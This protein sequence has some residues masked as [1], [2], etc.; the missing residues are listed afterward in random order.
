MLLGAFGKSDPECA[1][2]RRA[3]VRNTTITKNHSQS[4][5]RHI[6]AGGICYCPSCCNARTVGVVEIPK[7]PWD[8][9]CEQV[10]LWKS[11]LLKD[12]SLELSG[13]HFPSFF[14]AERFE[15]RRSLVLG[16]G[17]SVGLGDG[18]FELV[19]LQSPHRC[20]R[21][22]KSVV[23]AHIS[24]AASSDKRASPTMLLRLLR[25]RRL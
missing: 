21:A 23:Q 8:G 19:P 2:D 13:L 24:G 11:A 7:W 3:Q 12:T 14:G 1:C 9:L 5:L 15:T 4:F 16:I 10:R 6:P 25:A 18:N 17:K 22:I 20:T